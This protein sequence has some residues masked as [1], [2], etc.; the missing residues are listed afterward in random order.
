MVGSWPQSH[1]N[2]ISIENILKLSAKLVR[3]FQQQQQQEQLL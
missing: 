3:F 1:D 2:A